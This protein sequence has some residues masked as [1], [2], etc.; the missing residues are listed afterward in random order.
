MLILI[1]LRSSRRK[2]SDIY[3]SS[4][5]CSVPFCAVDDK[6]V[7]IVRSDEGGQDTS[8]PVDSLNAAGDEGEEI[9]EGFT[10]QVL[11]G[12]RFASLLRFPTL[13]TVIPAHAWS[14]EEH[15][16]F[17]A[18]FQK[19]S[20]TLMMCSNSDFLQP[21][22][23]QPGLEERINV[24]AVLPRSLWIEVLSFTHRRCKWYSVLLWKC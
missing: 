9:G 16:Y 17:P 8:P 14:P 6:L 20:S 3:S 7:K 15:Q 1:T 23:P 18:A 11:S 22:P 5:H 2:T 4:H 24:S 10:L 12:V 19:A 21:L 13:D